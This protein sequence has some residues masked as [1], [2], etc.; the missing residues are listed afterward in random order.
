[1]DSIASQA[2]PPHNIHN[3][4]PHVKFQELFFKAL[5][6]K[7]HWL[8][9][10]R[11]WR[12]SEGR[13][14]RVSMWSH[15]VP[16]QPQPSKVRLISLD[17]TSWLKQQKNA[18]LLREDELQYLNKQ[19][20]KEMFGDFQPFCHAK[21]WNYPIET[22]IHGYFNWMIPNLDMERTCCLIPWPSMKTHVFWMPG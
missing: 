19:L 13:L 20:L 9:E 2:T 21:P 3:V 17:F 11:L 15:D 22:S 10:G 12:V 4:L 7:T 8:P 5:K 6:K 14:W 16:W 1:M 18:D